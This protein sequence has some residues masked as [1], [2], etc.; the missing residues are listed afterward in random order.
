MDLEQLKDAVALSAL[1]YKVQGGEERRAVFISSCDTL[2]IQKLFR[3][4]MFG[5]E[6]ARSR[7]LSKHFIL[8]GNGL[9]AY[10]TCA[11]LRSE[12]FHHRCVLDLFCGHLEPGRATKGFIHAHGDISFGAIGYS[13]SLV[14]KLRWTAEVLRLGVDTFWV[15]LDVV[16]LR[17]PMEFVAQFYGQADHLMNW[18]HCDQGWRFDGDVYKWKEGDKRTMDFNC[19]TFFLWANQR[20]VRHIEFWVE[21][22]R[23]QLYHGA[24][25]QGDS[26]FDQAVF[27][28]IVSQSLYQTEVVVHGEEGQDARLEPGRVVERPKDFKVWPWSHLKFNSYCPGRCGC[29]PEW[30]NQVDVGHEHGTL[31][32]GYPDEYLLEMYT[33]HMN[34]LTPKDQKAAMMLDWIKMVY[35]KRLNLTLPPLLSPPSAGRRLRRRLH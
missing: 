4:F 16:V 23:K 12:G 27:N 15:D 2:C 1:A 9:A 11:Q 30:N 6:H 35:V 17:D 33:M 7:D 25:A 21:V 8:V 13:F 3:L 14:Q 5:M 10:T 34:C 22:Y 29:G 31:K 28:G 32:C 26:T 18:E 19:G 24:N 20:A